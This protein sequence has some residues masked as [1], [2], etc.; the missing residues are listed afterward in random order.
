MSRTGAAIAS[1]TKDAAAALPGF[2][3]DVAKKQDQRTTFGNGT[4]FSAG[5]FIAA[6]SHRP[7]I[8]IRKR[9]P[10]IWYQV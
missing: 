10:N 9:P 1:T 2:I 3:L 5:A 7:S 8:N 4:A 6:R